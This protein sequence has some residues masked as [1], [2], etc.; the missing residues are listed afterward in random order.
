MD[1]LFE[2]MGQLTAQILNSPELG[3]VAVVVGYVYMRSPWPPLFCPLACSPS[4][5]SGGKPPAATTA[6]CSAHPLT[7]PPSSPFGCP[8]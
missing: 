1:Q 5:P 7:R 4:S 3:V 6:L 2:G 8:W